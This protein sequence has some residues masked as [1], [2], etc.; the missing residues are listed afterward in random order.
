LNSG[1]HFCKAGSLLLEPRLQSILLWS[2]W[3]WGS[4]ELFAQAGLKL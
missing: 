1:L 4:R 3:R 2:L